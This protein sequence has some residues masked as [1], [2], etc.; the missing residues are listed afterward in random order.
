MYARTLRPSE[1]IA[2][3]RQVIKEQED[4]IDLLKGAL[5]A[6]GEDAVPTFQP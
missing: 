3:Q 2:R 5:A 1:V 4:I 6:T